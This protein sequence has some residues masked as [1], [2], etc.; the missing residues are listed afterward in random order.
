MLKICLADILFM[1]GFEVEYGP[2]Y[3]NFKI[4]NAA[5]KFP[6][7]NFINRYK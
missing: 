6:K 7:P 4:D 5:C 2:I 3:N 1:K